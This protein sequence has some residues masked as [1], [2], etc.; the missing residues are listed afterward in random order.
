MIGSKLRLILHNHPAL[1]KFGRCK[2]LPSI[3]WYIDL[4]KKLTNG[5]LIWKQGCIWAID[6]RSTSFPGAA[7][8]LFIHQWT[9]KKMAFNGYPKTKLL[10]FSVKLM[11]KKLRIRKTYC[12]MDVITFLRI[13]CKNTNNKKACVCNPTLCKKRKVGQRLEESL[14]RLRGKLVKNVKIFWINN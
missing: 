11:G 6:H 1:T 3:R 10:N 12:S 5:I 8:Q 13:I 14:E 4:E 7:A 2:Q 9:I